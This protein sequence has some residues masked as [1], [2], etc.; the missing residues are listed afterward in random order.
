MTKMAMMKFAASALVLGTATIGYSVAGQATAPAAM[1]EAKAIAFA[2]DAASRASK[3]M[4]KKRADRALAFAEAAVAARPTNAD[5]RMLLGQVYLAAGRFQSAE[6]SF[7]DALT[8]DPN[9]ERAALN[10]ALSHVALG[11]QAAAKSTLAEYREKLAAADYGLATALAGDPGEAVRVLEA[12]ARGPGADAKTRQNLALAYALNGQWTNAKVLAV[13]DLSPAEADVRLVQW[14]SFAKPTGSYDQV[15]SLLNVRPVADAGQPTRLALVPSNSQVA[16]IAVPLAAPAAVVA[17]P[18]PTPPTPVAEIAQIDPTPVA[19]TAQPAFETAPTAVIVKA[20]VEAKSKPIVPR[21][22]PVIRASATPIKRAAFTPAV[23][24]RKA[25]GRFVV[26]LGAF[27]TASVAERAWDRAA[28]RFGLAS[29][30]VVKGTARVRSAN[31]VRLSIAGFDIRSDADRLCG[32]IRSSGGVCFVR[33]TQGDAPTQWVQR[34]KPT[35]MAS[36]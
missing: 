34:A 22:A 23:P 25:S 35:R 1:S 30:D 13:Q 11:K 19:D 12:A 7:A 27:S 18:E 10:L 5:Y 8:L 28:G 6:T 33:M 21:F 3:A 20:P 26:Q 15:A 32:K 9:R 4:A 36:R 2:A 24:M 14:A 29:Y 16:S 17:L 31:L